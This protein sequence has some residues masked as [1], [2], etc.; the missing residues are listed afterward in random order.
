MCKWKRGDCESI[1]QYMFQLNQRL[2]ELEKSDIDINHCVLDEIIK[3][4]IKFFNY[5]CESNNRYFCLFLLIFTIS[6]IELTDFN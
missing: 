6:Q 1:K 5:I 3:T 4:D 2:E